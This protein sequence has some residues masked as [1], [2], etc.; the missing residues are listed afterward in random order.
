MSSSKNIVFDVV[1]TL[2]SYDHLFNA[3]DSRLGPRLRAEGIKPQLLANTWFETAEREYTYLSMSGKYVPFTSVFR[4]VFVR[5]LWMAGIPE[6]RTFASTE[7]LE[8]LMDAHGA[9]QMRPDA[10]ECVQKLRDAGFTVWGFTSG[11]LNR[12]A[13]Y[14]REAG[15]N[16]PAEN[17]ISCDSMGIGKPDPAVYQ[18]LL[19]RLMEENEGKKP[20]FAA[21]HMW[22]V[23]AA[24]RTGFMGAYCTVLEKEPLLDLF[25]DMDVVDDTLGGM[26]NKIIVKQASAE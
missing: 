15:I 8:Y 2:V 17:L 7:D 18:P 5:V 9:L 1:G 23:S 19:D 6:P 22:D 25:G 24:R 20:W 4:A 26:A 21:A 16:M 12:V 14:F 13:G 11:D 3:I 10:V